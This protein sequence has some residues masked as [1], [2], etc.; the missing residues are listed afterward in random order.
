MI[1]WLRSFFNWC[2]E[3]TDIVLW[4]ISSFGAIIVYLFH[5]RK[6]NK[7]EKLLQEIELNKEKEIQE[8]K[9]KAI[10]RANCFRKINSRI[11]RVFNSAEEATATNIRVEILTDT[12]HIYSQENPSP[13]PS[14]LPK[15]HFDVSFTPYIGAP[16]YFEIKLI[17]DDN[18]AK[19]RVEYVTL[20]I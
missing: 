4:G 16:E 10:I 6:K 7:R 20:Q 13:F 14:L 5:T 8:N 17:W 11:I 15:G 19:D 3:H 12:T 1:D 9:K 18:Y 2:E